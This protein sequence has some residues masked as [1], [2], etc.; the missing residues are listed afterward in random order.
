[1]KPRPVAALLLPHPER[2]H[3]ARLYEQAASGAL[4]FV[5]RFLL[6]VVVHHR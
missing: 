3:W 2:G 1:M 6:L 4:L 5:A